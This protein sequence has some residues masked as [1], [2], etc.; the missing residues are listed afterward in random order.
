MLFPGRDFEHGQAW[1]ASV[2]LD[3]ESGKGR[4]KGDSLNFQT[5][6]LASTLERADSNGRMLEPKVR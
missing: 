6:N 4:R 3:G 1:V 2:S 5:P